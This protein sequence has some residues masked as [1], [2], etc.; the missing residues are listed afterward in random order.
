MFV[1]WSATYTTFKF[2]RMY[3]YRYQI[4]GQSLRT[5]VGDVSSTT[6][7]LF[8]NFLIQCS[9]F[10]YFKTTRSYPIEIGTIPLHQG[11]MPSANFSPSAPVADEMD[12]PPQYSASAPR[13][14]QIGFVVMSV[15]P[16]P[17][18]YPQ[19][20]LHIRKLE[21]LQIFFKNL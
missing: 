13:H 18:E 9:N 19:S 12:P 15:P 6:L 11:S 21:K 4:S 10:R 17:A 16:Y 2:G 8:R 1:S 7:Y 20:T 3:Y 5:F 14:S